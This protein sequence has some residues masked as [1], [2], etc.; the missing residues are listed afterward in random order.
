MMREYENF[1]FAKSAAQA[2]DPAGAPDL[3]KLLGARPS[4][5]ARQHA[6]WL[7]MQ[8]LPMVKG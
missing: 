4:W 2:V 5:G 6:V 1:L 3:E 8:S 7:L